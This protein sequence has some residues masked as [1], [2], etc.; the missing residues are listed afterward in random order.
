MYIFGGQA[1]SGQPLDDLW[2]LWWDGSVVPPRWEWANL[3]A[4][5]VIN[6]APPT[7]RHGHSAIWDES[8]KRMVLFGG[9]GAGGSINDAAVYILSINATNDTLTWGIATVLSATS[10][11]ARALH[12][13]A[14]DITRRTPTGQVGA[15]L[16]AAMFGGETA[17]GLSD[18]LWELWVK[19]GANEVVWRQLTPSGAAPAARRGAAAAI[20]ERYPLAITVSGGAL[21]GGATDATTWE[22]VL[23]D[24]A[25]WHWEQ[26]ASAPTPLSG[27]S[28]LRERRQL[29]MLQPEVY[30][31]VTNLW[32]AF[33]GR[34]F[35]FSYHMLFAG[36]DGG[37]WHTGPNAFAQDRTWRL[38]R[39]SGVWTEQA[40]PANGY[41]DSATG[42]LYRPNR[43]LKVGDLQPGLAG[44]PARPV[45]ESLRLDEPTPTR[46]WRT[47]GNELA[48][49]R[50]FHTV[51][52]L[53]TGE[54]ITTGG[55]LY[56]NVSDT[57]WVAEVPRRRP[58]LWDPTYAWRTHRWA[59]GTEPTSRRP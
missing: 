27:H 45:S 58:E 33:G 28:L 51:S 44:I 49:A 16:H 14:P 54:A 42:V 31:P 20:Y 5:A 7:A 46:R 23:D 53:P 3:A 13:M 1:Q 39:T 38:D 17:A 41:D 43:I 40:I 30:D 19:P 37:L 12:A 36:S 59:G 25:S 6:G 15:W 48:L 2:K 9:K 22:M 26:K 21:A 24:H 47:A 4:T 56:T 8:G 32:T 18:E 50:Q 10:P 55:T 34:N 52:L 29:T 57:N 11:S 35:Q